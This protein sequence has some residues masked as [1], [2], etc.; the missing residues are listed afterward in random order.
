MDR[1]HVGRRHVAHLLIGAVLMTAAAACGPSGQDI[2]SK[3][4]Y[5]YK[6]ANN[7][8]YDENPQSAMEELYQALEYDPNHAKV[9]H[10]L[11]F[12]FFGRRDFP[13]ALRH[14]ERAVKLDPDFDI[15]VANLGNLMLA[16]GEWERAIPSFQR[17]L[18]KPLYRTP[19]LAYNNIG[20]AH[21]NLGQYEESIKQYKMAIFMN[22]KFCLGHNNLGR[23]RAHLG[24]TN[25]ALEAFG[26][27]TQFCPQYAE[28][29]YFMGRIYLALNAAEEAL[30]HFQTCQRLAPDSPYGKKCTEA[31]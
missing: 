14:I 11:G 30:T 15:A 19:Y 18:N 24:D 4:D 3:A 20:W 25:E 26:K 5:H 31:L 12:I 2:S 9:H 6:L 7:L 10:L 28:P 23:V 13:R 16:M 27:A 29:H 8:F 17:L 22:P 1:S 21:Y